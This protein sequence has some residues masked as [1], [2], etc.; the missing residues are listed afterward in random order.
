MTKRKI[1]QINSLYMTYEKQKD[2]GAQ[3]QGVPT[4]FRFTSFFRSLSLVW[5]FAVSN[6]LR[7]TVRNALC[8]KYWLYKKDSESAKVDSS[9]IILKDLIDANFVHGVGHTSES[10][11]LFKVESFEAPIDWGSDDSNALGPPALHVRQS[12]FV[13]VHHN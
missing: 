8:R 7:H 12:D 11:L 4:S 9:L 6:L 3:V 10:Q 1:L 2:F 5:E 13:L